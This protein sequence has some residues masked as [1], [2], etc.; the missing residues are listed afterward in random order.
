MLDATSETKERAFRASRPK[1]ASPDLPRSLRGIAL[2]WSFRRVAAYC[3]TMASF[4]T[5]IIG[6]K[7]Y[8]SGNPL[9][10]A[11]LAIA[12]QTA[13]LSYGHLPAVSGLK[14]GYKHSDLLRFAVLLPCLAFSVWMS[15]LCAFSEYRPQVEGGYARLALQRK[16]RYSSA[17]LKRVKTEALT[18]VNQQV[19]ELDA[20]AKEKGRL[21]RA[22]QGR[23]GQFYVWEKAS[24]LKDKVSDLKARAEK[25]AQVQ[26]VSEMMPDNLEEARK[27]IDDAQVG[28]SAVLA[29]APSDFS[30]QAS[31]PP[32]EEE[33]P[34]DIQAAFVVELKQ[35]SPGGL[36]CLLFGLAIDL[37]T[38]GLLRT[39][40]PFRTVPELW[41]DARRYRQQWRDALSEPLCNGGQPLVIE[42]ANHPEL[43]LHLDLRS[44]RE[45]Y[46]DDL[47]D[48][49]PELEQ[50]ISERLG[51]EVSIREAESSAGLRLT[52][53]LPLSSQLEAD[54]KVVL[55]IQQRTVV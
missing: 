9:I 42:V 26:L 52:S 14:R 30:F 36:M 8:A 3:M 48:H 12:M 16:L 50:I 47:G 34:S 31:P 7:L 49:F 40:R 44:G 1:S 15:A 6:A 18:L 2:S 53:A 10:A 22:L 39:E 54:R 13:I 27:R 23:R 45:L 21:A 35:R 33:R 32:P 41:R 29:Q 25:I 19:S 46:L 4:G 38:I 11:A 28:I 20:Q 37:I 24:K 51:E 5:T 17:E 43:N 55:I